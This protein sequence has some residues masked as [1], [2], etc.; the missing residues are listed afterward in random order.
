MRALRL[1]TS[2][3]LAALLAACASS[4]TYTPH[5]FPMPGGKS[6]KVA[7]GTPN[8]APPDPAPPA[9]PPAAPVAPP[10]NP[11]RPV[12]PPTT[13]TADGYALS[14]TALSLR[15]APYQ[16]GGTL[17]SGFDCS[18][19][20]QYVF[21]Q[22]GIKVP[23]DV[24]EQ[25]KLGKPVDPG[26]LQPGDLLFFSTTAPGPTHVGIAIGGNQFVHA[27]SE[28]GVVRVEQLSVQYWSSRFVGARRVD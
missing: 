17:P 1:V 8:T 13:A 5:P 21:G 6:G 16:N 10:A 24:K 26:R 7:G 23:R 22:N 11:R 18:G 15:G 25:F 4:G 19:F 14:S 28:K 12:V 27:P 20:V 2:V 9:A 3:S